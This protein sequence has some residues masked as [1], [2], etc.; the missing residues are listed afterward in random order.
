[1][2]SFSKIFIPSYCLTL[3]VQRLWLLP[4]LANTEYYCLVHFSHSDRGVAIH[5][6]HIVV[7]NYFPND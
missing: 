6:Y 4:I 1:M 2:E 7:L 3:R 5:W